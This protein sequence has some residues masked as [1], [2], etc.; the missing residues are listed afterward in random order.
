MTLE[1][2]HETLTPI[3]ESVSTEFEAEDVVVIL[4][5][6]CYCKKAYSPSMGMSEEEKPRLEDY[7]SKVYYI[8]RT[9]R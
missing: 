2:A 7:E 1:K 3:R 5:S 4:S 8:P 9:D 6:P